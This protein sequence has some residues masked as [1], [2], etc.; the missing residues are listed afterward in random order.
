MPRSWV[1]IDKM[2]YKKDSLSFTF[3]ILGLIAN[4]VYFFSLYK[5][6]NNFFYTLLMGISVIYNLVF[7]LVVFLAAEEVKAY[8]RN[9]SY[10]LFAISLIQIV[11][12]FIYPR[13]ALEAE[14]ISEGV[15]RNL[16][17]WLIVSGVFLLLS[18]VK[19][20]WSSTVLKLYLVG[21]IKF[22]ETDEV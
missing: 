8:R 12:I 18:A 17:I 4:L 2:K 11:R 3:A 16:V 13:L 9:Y 22:P 14:V 6:N 20:F 5:N 19:S 1:A 7:M 15:H 21:K 10:V